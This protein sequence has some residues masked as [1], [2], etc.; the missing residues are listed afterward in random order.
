MSAPLDQHIGS[1]RMLLRRHRRRVLLAIALLATTLIAGVG[2]LGV[3]GG[4]LTAAALTYGT[5]G[6]FNFFTPSAGIRGLTL[7]R[8]VSRYLEKLLGHDVMLRIARDLRSW[9]FARALR[10]TP[11]QLG[12]LRT[13]E[14]LA[15]L[16]VLVLHAVAR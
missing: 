12:R 4:F 3:S 15:R 10:L 6:S 11:G 16:M 7:A 13:G 2:L 14:L 1:T 8:I 9:F 5:L